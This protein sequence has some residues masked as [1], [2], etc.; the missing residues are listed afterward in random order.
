MK[1]L[2]FSLAALLII[3]LSSCAPM[4]SIAIHDF[5]SGY[6]NHKSEEEGSKKIYAEVYEDSLVIYKMNPGS[7]KDPDPESVTGTRISTVNPDSYLF[8]SKFI[9]NSIEIDL[10]TMLTKLRPATYGVPFQLNANLNALIYMG[11]RK[12]YYII[13]SHK[14]PLNKDY[15]SVKQIGYDFGI[16]AGIGITPINPTVTNN[17]TSLEYDGIVF[18]K[19]IGAFITINYLSVGITLGFDNLI[20]SDS[21]IWIYNNR[22]YLGL[23]LGIANF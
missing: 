11:A 19:G 3:I 18:Q 8:N 2:F 12:D 15:S 1:K 4:G 5:D 14:L 23:A 20:S 17:N 6:Y 10:S 7:S 9:K 22:P 13:K 21:K 16:F